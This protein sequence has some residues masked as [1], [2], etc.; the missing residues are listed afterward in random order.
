[1]RSQH[2]D[3]T[4]SFDSPISQQ[5]Q[6]PQSPYLLRM[7]AGI[8]LTRQRVYA[9]PA[10]SESVRRQLHL[11]SGRAHA[12]IAGVECDRGQVAELRIPFELAAPGVNVR[13]DLRFGLNIA[14]GRG[15]GAAHDALQ[16]DLGL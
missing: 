8:G 15:I 3:Y 5:T 13:L 1:M 2:L 14:L 12:L 4:I 11:D 7:I 16:Q 6:R 9:R 10:L